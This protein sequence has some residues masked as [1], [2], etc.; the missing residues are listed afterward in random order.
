MPQDDA[1]DNKEGLTNLVLLMTPGLARLALDSIVP[2]TVL[3]R[4]RNQSQLETKYITT[5]AI[6]D[7]LPASPD[8]IEGAEGIAYMLLRNAPSPNDND[9]IPFQD[10]AQKP[11]SLTF[12]MPKVNTDRASA[13]RL[14]P[15]SL[16]LPLSQTVF[17][18]GLVSTMILREYTH[19]GKDASLEL[20]SER[21]LESQTLQLPALPTEHCRHTMYAPLVPLTPFRKINY[22]MGNI[23][24]KLSAQH[25]WALQPNEEAESKLIENTEDAEQDVPASQ[26]L[27]RAVSKYFETLDLQPETVSVWALVIPKTGEFPKID[28]VLRSPV[29][30]SIL[31]ADELAIS[32]AWDAHTQESQETMKL[33]S[34]LIRRSMLHGARL[35]RVLSG[36][37]GWGKKAGLLSLDPDVEYSTRE[38][39]QDN[40]WQFDFDA[41]DDATGASVEAQ[42]NQALGQ[43]VKEGESIMFLLAPKLQNLPISLAAVARKSAHDL[44]ETQELE[45]SFGVIPSSIDD[46]AR[47]PESDTAPATIQHYPGLFG[48]LSE[49]GMALRSDLLRRATH[50]SKFDVPFGR[51]N[52][53]QYPNSK[54]KL[55][56]YPDALG[57]TSS[58]GTGQAIEPSAKESNVEPPGVF[59][60]KAKVEQRTTPM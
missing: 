2:S 59:R 27:E 38:L 53:K 24:R 16:Q 60:D 43:I 1:S 36:G 31:A 14:E 55:P 46:V 29:M 47:H 48:M 6:V 10:S 37:G 57:K 51:F 56:Y 34:Q 5:T 54:G 18:T 3:K 20:I 45:L 28:K 39:R 13:P 32:A 52:Y 15:H 58:G 41:P 25:T 42:K 49:G 4:L 50:Q 30:Q 40:G 12:Q 8:Q 21:K 23:I 9:Q 44:H 19:G 35:T 7:R 26:D 22:V 11:G 33:F 17:T